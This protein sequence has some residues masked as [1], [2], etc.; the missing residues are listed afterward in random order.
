MPSGDRVP[1]EISVQRG[2]RV[3]LSM[4]VSAAAVSNGSLLWVCGGCHVSYPRGRKHSYLYGA[5]CL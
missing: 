4:H 5:L 3:A 1:G 2:N